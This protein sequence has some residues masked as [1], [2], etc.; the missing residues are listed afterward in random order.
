M[1]QSIMFKAN[2]YAGFRYLESHE[3]RD[4]C[5]APGIAY[6]TEDGL[7]VRRGDWYGTDPDERARLGWGMVF[8]DETR[9]AFFIHHFLTRD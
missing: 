6:R 1:I 9:V 2:V 8:P 3:I 4:G 5:A 7:E